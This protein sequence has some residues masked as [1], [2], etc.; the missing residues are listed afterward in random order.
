M[1]KYD[2][3]ITICNPPLNFMEPDNYDYAKKAL[4]DITYYFDEDQLTN[5]F[6]SD[7]VVAKNKPI[8]KASMGVSGAIALGQSRG[9]FI[10][11]WDALL[12]DKTPIELGDYFSKV[13]KKMMSEPWYTELY[14]DY[15]TIIPKPSKPSKEKSNK[16]KEF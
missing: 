9:C 12:R 1:R 14:E 2:K 11:E 4:Q 3:Y 7:P 16:E 15:K 10:I 6:L 8:L 13:H 5:F